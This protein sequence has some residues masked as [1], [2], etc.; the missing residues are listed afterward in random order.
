MAPNAKREKAK[1]FSLRLTT[2]ERQ[3]LEAQ[4][5]DVPL[6]IYVRELVLGAGAGKR[7][8]R[9]KAP[10]ED[11][12]LLAQVLA[13]LGRKGFAEHIAGLATAAASGSLFVDEE[14][15][16]ELR[17]ASD[18]IRAMRLMLMEALGFKVQD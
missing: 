17:R 14:V 9:R 16:A 7:A 4:A 2:S 8:K 3:A 15:T 18:D 12:A 1:P 5:G 13:V 6:G 11:L 10:V